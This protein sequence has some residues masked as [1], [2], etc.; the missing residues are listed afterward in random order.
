MFGQNSFSKGSLPPAVL[1][2]AL[3]LV[4]HSA[5]ANDMSRTGA[6]RGQIT[7][8]DG[9]AL[10]GANVIIPN[11]ER[12]ASSDLS[13]AYIIRHLP[14][15]LL[16]IS[17]KY[18]GYE[19][20]TRHVEVRTNNTVIVDFVLKETFIESEPVVV[21]GRPVATNP[22]KS[23]QDISYLS[24]REKL[25]LQ[26]SSL[27]KTIEKVPGVYN[28]SSGAAAGKPVIRG[29]SGERIRVL[30]NGIVQEYQQYGE[31]HGPN[32]DAFNYER[33][34]V[35]KGAASLLYGSDAL[36][37]AV[38]VISPTIPSA[39]GQ[40]P[41]L[42][43]NVLS[44]YNSNN[45]EIMGG[46]KLEGAAKRLGFRASLAVRNAEDFHAPNE[47]TFAETGQRGDPKF[48]GKIEHTDYQQLSG[49]FGANYW[50]DWGRLTA[51]L[52]G[53]HNENNFLLPTG[54]PIG[55]GLDHLNTTLDGLVVKGN[56]ILKPKFSYQRNH[57]RATRPGL[58]REQLADSSVVDLLLQVYTGRLE[59]ENIHT[60]RFS[61][62]LGA[63]IK[64]YDHENQGLVPLQPTGH[65]TNLA[66]FAF[67]E[68]A[69]DRLTFDVGA[70]FDYKTQKFFAAAGNPLLPQDDDRDYASFSAALGASYQLTANLTA[71]ANLSRGFRTPSFYNLYVYGLH[72]GV[73]AFQ[74]GNPDL[75]NETSLDLSASLRYKTSRIEAFVTAF[76]NTIDDYIFLFS[77]PDNPLAPPAA[78]APFVFAHDQ[79]DARINGLDLGLTAHL[80]SRMLVSGSF[81]TIASKFLGGANEDGELPLMPATRA[82]A[83]LKYILPNFGRLRHPYLLLH[84]KRTWD[85]DAAG[86]YEPFGQFD[87]GIGP[88]IPFGVASTDAYTLV[89]LGLGFDFS[90]NHSLINLDIE[91]SNLLDEAYRDFLD[92]YKGYALG[93][94][95]GVNIKLNVP[96]GYNR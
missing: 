30:N 15:G 76:H 29:H 32:V 82:N 19:S 23:P 79:A 86:E 46:V 47:A 17:V 89:N 70:R 45:S 57:R 7:S 51:T 5:T 66:A 2:L 41:F 78:E 60:G 38:N 74:I 73:F 11:I 14:V 10:I 53:W 26:S 84:L 37:G 95:R 28:I 33:V 58:S 22:L 63:E 77:D 96:I 24:G 85:K 68:I 87:D 34:E 55:I 21:T 8:Q 3:T 43:S 27:G 67:E 36:G 90:F 88:D 1:L 20:Q 50:T 39:I 72:G 91:I 92:T 80:F 6:I 81:S 65:Y 93:A 31:R 54:D 44:Q 56:I 48:T 18:L 59:V 12:G 4:T 25:R 52:D 16:H 42:R 83:E 69:F 13:G 94:G 9:T 71:A 61:G 35:I 49:T 75:V 64:Y 40:K 62:T